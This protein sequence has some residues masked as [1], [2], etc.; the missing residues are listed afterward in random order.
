MDV[1]LSTFAPVSPK[2]GLVTTIREARLKPEFAD[3]YPGI[4]PDVWMPAT[5]LAQKLVQ[6]AHARRREGRYTRTFDPTHFEFRGG[7]TNA[8]PRGTRTRKTDR[9]K[10]SPESSE[11]TEQEQ[12][13]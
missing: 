5:E 11:G 8:R 9:V 12:E 4:T 6:R 3:E 1:S 7:L 2:L 10:L 13:L